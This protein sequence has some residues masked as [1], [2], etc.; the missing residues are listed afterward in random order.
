MFEVFWTDC[1]GRGNSCVFLHRE[2][3]EDYAQLCHDMGDI[4]V[5]IECHEKEE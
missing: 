4:D 2:D 5:Y 1:E 3:A